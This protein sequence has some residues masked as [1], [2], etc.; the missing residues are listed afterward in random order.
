MPD[1]L[2]DEE[3][4]VFAEAWQEAAG[5]APGVGL[6][7]V[8]SK[9]AVAIKAHYSE[10]TERAERERDEAQQAIGRIVGA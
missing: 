8:A 5:M 7:I 6:S 10:R 4:A 9:F 1:P 2:T 3:R